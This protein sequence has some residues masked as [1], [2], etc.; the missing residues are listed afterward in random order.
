MNLK[1]LLKTNVILVLIIFFG[2]TS[3]FGTELNVV[4]SLSR[5]AN[6]QGQTVFEISYKILNDQLTFIKQNDQFVASIEGTINIIKANRILKTEKF[7]CQI[8]AV[9][10]LQTKSNRYFYL[11]KISLTLTKPGYNIEILFKD[12][13]SEKETVWRSDLKVFETKSI[14]SD[15]ELSK[16]VIADTSG[17]ME[18]F[19]R[20]GQI[21]FVEPGKMFNTT[22][23]SLNIYFELYKKV[24]EP[25]KAFK[26]EYKIYKENK[27]VF[28]ETD[29][30]LIRFSPL[31][32]LKSYPIM[33]WEEGK[34]KIYL[35][36]YDKSN[37]LLEDKETEFIVFKGV[38]K[39]ILRMFPNDEDEYKLMKYF[40]NSNQIKTW[41][42]I[43]NEAR[44]AFIDK[45]WASNDK[46]KDD[47]KNDFYDL[48]KSRIETSRSFVRFTDGW[49]SDMGR[50][51]IK[52][53]KPESVEK[54][55]TDA[56]NKYSVKD[57]QIWKYIGPD[58]TYVFVDL[59]GSGNQKLV[60]SKNDDS[61]YTDP[62]WRTYLNSDFDESNL[63]YESSP[64]LWK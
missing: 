6:E 27:L 23:D 22:Q 15:L 40:M 60:Y 25:E 21:Y 20:L 50:I 57:Y 49:K 24:E 16:S 35:G 59:Q 62:K 32:T 2:C 64:D 14:M 12:K 53:G 61:E 45:F 41:N 10:Q 5:F 39:I 56:T 58:R 4:T 48:V 28:S 8:G 7:D 9:N 44:K 17:I 31:C 52:Y 63:D 30:T 1:K 36:V 33:N 11:D 34:Y 18:K 51:Y 3:L 55:S 19:N 42:N 29:S 38:E 37:T 46:N 54:K 13:N 43:S 47:D 26:V